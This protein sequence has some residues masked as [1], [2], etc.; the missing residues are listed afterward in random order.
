MTAASAAGADHLTELARTRQLAA[1]AHT[2][3]LHLSC[4]GLL[5]GQA[6]DTAGHAA[7]LIADAL[8]ELRDLAAQL[9]EAAAEQVTR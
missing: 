1:A 4:G 7:A 6:A 2:A 5:T 8:A 3:A 9:A